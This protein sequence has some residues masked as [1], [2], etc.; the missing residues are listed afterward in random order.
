MTEVL[1]KAMEWYMTSVAQNN[2]KAQFNIGQFYK[3]GLGVPQDY[4]K[5]M[6]WFMKAAA[7]A[8]YSIVPDA[9]VS[10]GDLYRN[11]LGVPKSEEKAKEWYTKAANLGNEMAKKNLKSLNQSSTKPEVK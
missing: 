7:Q 5:A 9:Q 1:L 8:G 3:N 10:I 2:P 11:G 4:A 6:E